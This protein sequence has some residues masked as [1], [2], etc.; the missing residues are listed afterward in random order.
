[1]KLWNSYEAEENKWVISSIV[2]MEEHIRGKAGNA[3]FTYYPNTNMISFN[4]PRHR[5][6]KGFN[7]K[8][9]DSYDIN[10]YDPY[11]YFIENASSKS[12]TWSLTDKHPNCEANAIMAD[13]QASKVLNKH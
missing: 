1:M 10:I 12:M 13:F 5:I 4:D 6:W 2:A 7:S 9:R 11:P 8:I 3:Y